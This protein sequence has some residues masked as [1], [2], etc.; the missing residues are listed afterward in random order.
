MEELSPPIDG[1]DSF[2]QRSY[3]GA[4][5]GLRAVSI[6]LVLLHHATR[7]PDHSLIH[8]LQENGRYGVAF[9]FV[10]SGFL[11]C[12]LFLQEEYKT[13][14]INLLK[15]YGRRSLRLLPLYYAVLLLQMILVFVLHQYSPENQLLFRDKLCS[16]LFYYSNWLPTA[17]QGPFFCA[18]S[19]AVEEQFYLL[20]G[21][22]LFFVSQRAIITLAVA[23]LLIKAVVY[24]VFGAVDATSTVFRVLFSYREPILLGV[25]VAFLLNHRRGYTIVSRLLRSP[26]TVASIGILTAAWLSGHLMKHESFWDSQLLYLLMM[27]T[28]AGVVIRGDTPVLGN[29]FLRHIGKVSYGIYLFHMFVIS[30]VRKL[31]GVSSPVIFLCVS[32]LISIGIASVVYKFFEEPIIRFYKKRLS[33]LRSPAPNLPVATGPAAIPLN[34]QPVSDP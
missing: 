5:D 10:I 30:A 31:P 29:R 34:P 7:F 19:L 28:L 9:F 18:W 4:L 25:L 8:T 13:G 14:R 2:R 21:L 11:I 27:L 15:F 16:Y 17:T 22:L 3:F 1:F 20:F 33:P 32:S 23:L 12:T 6:F 24:Q 26:W